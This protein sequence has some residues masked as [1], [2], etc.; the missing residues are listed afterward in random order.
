[1]K[2]KLTGVAVALALVLA[3]T[4]CGLGGG[5]QASILD[6][7]TLTI[8]VKPDQPG[9]GLRNAN[10]GYEGFDIDVAAYVARKLGFTDFRFVPAP[11]AQREN[12]LRQHRVDL[13]FATYSIT[14][15][16]KTKVDFAGPY[17]VAHQDTLVRAAETGI[18]NVRDLRGRSLCQVTGSNSWRRV[19]EERKVAVRLV[20]TASYSECL[21]KLKDGSVDAVSTDDL[22]LAGFA[23]TEDRSIKIVN[24]P[25]SDERY[26]V[27]I[28]KGDVDGCEAVN[29]AITE[30]YQ[31]GTA[32]KLLEK[33]FGPTGL[34]LTLTV[35]QFE[36]CG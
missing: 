27:G 13:I 28:A 5:A 15:E 10:G 1:M 33:W 16:R 25:F 26:G 21:D 36:G 23:G 24:A 22:I 8:G 34:N 3:A 19:S 18:D 2:N 14:P 29:K 31:D 7:E 6:K 17:Y 30:M 20:E 4:G 11:S 12:L 35:P 9:L 32:K